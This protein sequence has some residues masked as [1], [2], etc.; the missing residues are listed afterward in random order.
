MQDDELAARSTL[1]LQSVKEHC[2]D[3]ASQVHL[4]AR[5]LERCGSLDTRKLVQAAHKV[6]F[7]SPEGPLSV[8]EESNHCVLTPRIG[9]CQEDGQFKVVWEGS[10]QVKADPYLSTYGFAE[11][12]L[13]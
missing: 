13:R 3:T 2:H 11:F 1:S 6:R 12:G 8:D 7:E 9:V 10:A 5:A 4:F